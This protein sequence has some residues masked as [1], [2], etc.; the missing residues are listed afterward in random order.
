MKKYL[1]ITEYCTH[2]PYRIPKIEKGQFDLTID[3]DLIR[4]SV[5]TDQDSKSLISEGLHSVY[6]EALLSE[7]EIPLSNVFIYDDIDVDYEQEIAYVF[8]CPICLTTTI[9]SKQNL[10]FCPYCENNKFP[11]NLI[12]LVNTKQM[13]DI[14]VEHSDVSSLAVVKDNKIIFKD[15]PKVT[16][17]EELW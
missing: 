16:E 2:V 5:V 9:T 4:S 14:A 13:E 11:P 7:K 6:N 3:D 8:E 1:R 10:D 12:A 17:E 15:R